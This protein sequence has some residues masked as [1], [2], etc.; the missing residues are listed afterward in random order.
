MNS[1]FLF[2]ENTHNIQ[3]LQIIS[4]SKKKTVRYGLEK[5]SYRSPF[6]W[7][8][9]KITN[10]Q[11]LYMPSKQKIRIRNAEICECWLCKHY[12]GNLGL[13]YQLE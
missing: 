11:V 7:A 13:V 12:T 2:L 9:H 8:S 6:L 1:L 4:T 10:L 5:V 3:T